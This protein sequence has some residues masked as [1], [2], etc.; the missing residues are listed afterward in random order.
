MPGTD[1]HTHTSPLP[2]RHPHPFPPGE[3]CW[4][5]GRGCGPAKQSPLN[6]PT[7]PLPTCTMLGSR[8]WR[9][10]RP[11][12]R[13]AG[14]AGIRLSP[15]NT[16]QDKST[17][18]LGNF[19]WLHVVTYV[20]TPVHVVTMSTYVYTPLLA[21]STFLPATSYLR[22]PESPPTCAPAHISP[23][24]A[25]HSGRPS[26]I[27]PAPTYLHTLLHPPACTPDPRTSRAVPQPIASSPSQAASRWPRSH[28]SKEGGQLS[29]V[30]HSCEHFDCHHLD[31][32]VQR[33]VNLR[34]MGMHSIRNGCWVHSACRAR[35][36]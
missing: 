26:Y 15:A 29:R 30:V 1:Q 34:S 3:Q 12:T 20:H 6:I 16:A 13:Q 4:C 5:H 14:R 10:M 36:R 24:V 23:A 32:I 28:L 19:Q 35:Q 22:T 8:Q 7:S 2:A 33:L 18:R 11:C 17:A 25:A 21:T 9:R 27:P 31:I